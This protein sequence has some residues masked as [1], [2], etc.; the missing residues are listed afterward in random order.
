[1]RVDAHH[2]T[3]LSSTS[4]SLP[5]NGK[6]KFITLNV[7][8]IAL[9]VHSTIKSTNPGLLRKLARR[10]PIEAVGIGEFPPNPEFP[11]AKTRVTFVP[12]VF[13][14]SQSCYVPVLPC[15]TLQLGVWG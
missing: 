5:S 3:T 1:M 14:A 4:N 2:I 13:A 7:Q 15:P 11:R 12:G 6:A 9:A 10:A 8:L